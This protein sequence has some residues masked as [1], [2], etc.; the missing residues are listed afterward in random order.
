MK[1][2]PHMI[3]PFAHLITSCC[4]VGACAASPAP[5]EPDTTAIATVA[6]TAAP[7]AEAPYSAEPWLKLEEEMADIVAR[8]GKDCAAMGKALSAYAKRRA[9]EYK[10]LAAIRAK[11]DRPTQDAESNRLEARFTASGERLKGVQACWD[12]VGV[13]E[14]YA[15][16]DGATKTEP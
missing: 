7:A 2:T 1:Y 8:H 16:I 4:F 15:I 10:R 5:S 14:A 6:P 11:V 3:R 9:D 13:T 12:D